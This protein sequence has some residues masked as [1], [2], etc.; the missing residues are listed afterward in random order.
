MSLPVVLSPQA[1]SDA[2]KAKKYYAAISFPLAIAFIDELT[3]T[4]RFLGQHPN[5]G[6]AIKG[7]VRQFPLERFSYVVVYAVHKD[8]IRVV[9]V[10]HTRQHQGRK[11][12]RK[13]KP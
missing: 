13:R 12:G 1:A 8:V 7:N 6:V 9:R 2:N 10:F 5:G 4:F 11:L 3:V